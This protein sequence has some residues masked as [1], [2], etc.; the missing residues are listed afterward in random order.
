VSPIVYLPSVILTKRHFNVW[1]CEA[2]LHKP[3]IVDLQ[4]TTFC[5][6]CFPLYFCAVFDW[7]S[8]LNILCCLF[9]SSISGYHSLNEFCKPRPVCTSMYYKALLCYIN[10]PESEK[11]ASKSYFSSYFGM[12][13]LHKVYDKSG[14]ILVACEFSI[15]IL[16]LFFIFLLFNLSCTC[17]CYVHYRSK[18]AY[19]EFA[20]IL[21]F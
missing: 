17:T 1:Y 12:I 4:F 6:S 5:S 14:L 11:F 3:V 2:H 7:N 13:Y 16:S 8:W 19:Q 20:I 21:S 18:I 10:L 9:F 15:L